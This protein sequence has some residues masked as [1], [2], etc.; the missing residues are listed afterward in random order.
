MK[1][2][3]KTR[4]A[5]GIELCDVPIP[6]FAPDE[7]LVKLR[8]AALCGSDKDVYEYTPSVAAQNLKLPFIMGHELFGEVVDMGANV[9]GFSVGDMVASDSHMPCGSCYLCGTGKRHLCMKRG[10]LGRQK[11]GCF[12]EYMALPA[13]AA[14]RMAP[15]M[16]PEHGPLLEPLGV[17][18]HAAQRVPL[19]GRSVLVIGLGSIGI[20]EADVVRLMGAN[21]LIVCS[22]S[23]E[24]LKA[25]VEHGADH[26]INSKK[27]D[28]AA[29]VM[30]LTGGR[31]VDVVFEMSGVLKLFNI[32]IDCLAKGGSIVSV[33]LFNEDVVIPD[34]NS[35]VIRS[36]RILTSIFGRL[37]YE[38]WEVTKEFLALNRLELDRYVGAVLPLD[39]FDR[40]VEL[41]RRVS[42]RIVYKIS[43]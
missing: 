1:A 3:M 15:D 34:Y 6:S 26:G 17:A 40:G 8:T 14:I 30:R 9:T 41:S 23:D 20:M 19:S 42:G 31:G 13:V 43:D 24:K 37:M 27:A 32:G 36:E 16:K 2:V 35:R 33:G 22:T 18:I 38:T 39:E 7:L 4:P 11:D 29:E 10:V 28:V 12:A 5:P 25:A 21:R